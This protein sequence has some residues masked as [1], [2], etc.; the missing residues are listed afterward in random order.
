MV[1]NR[2]NNKL[3]DAKSFGSSFYQSL[4]V[5][6]K[7]LE[8]VGGRLDSAIHLLEFVVYSC[9]FGQDVFW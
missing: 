1:I 2:K 3:K 4:G 7:E 8:L 6:T 5:G 9:P